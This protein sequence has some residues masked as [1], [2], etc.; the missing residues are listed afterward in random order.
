MNKALLAS[1]LDI[2]WP[3]NL[4]SDMKVFAILDGA[5]DAR[6]SYQVDS[7][8]CEHDCL[9]AGSL[10]L[11]LQR[12]APYLVQIDR[13]DALS[14][15]IVEN[16]WRNSW[17]V[18]ARCDLGFRNIRKHVRRLLRVKDERGNRLVFRFYDPRVLR[19]YL[20]TCTASELA[21][22]FG[23]VKSFVMEAD[24]SAPEAIEMTFDGRELITV[25]TSLM[26]ALEA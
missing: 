4:P 13:D 17:C 3:A 22:V 11:A 2:I 10:P 15:W 19:V 25:V 24:G 23:P 18:F 5:R 1:I 21:A 14:R 26:P 9:Y 20:P 16:G 8:F 7:T 12:A 6:I